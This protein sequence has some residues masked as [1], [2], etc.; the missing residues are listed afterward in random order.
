MY[1]TYSRGLP[2]PFASEIRLVSIELQA[3]GALP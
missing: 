3:T 1:V 2:Q